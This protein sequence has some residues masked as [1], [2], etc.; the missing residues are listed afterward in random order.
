MSLLLL[1]FGAMLSSNYAS[2]AERAREA[3]GKAR[4]ST[5]IKSPPTRRQARSKAT[6]KSST[7]RKSGD[8][9]NRD[10]RRSVKFAPRSSP[11]SPSFSQSQN[12]RGAAS[13]DSRMGLVK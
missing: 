3:R 8:T 13:R 6:A 1:V 2:S 10:A 4:E 12:A 7:A 11:T 5:T 9:F